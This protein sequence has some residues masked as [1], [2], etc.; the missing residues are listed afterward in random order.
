VVEIERNTDLAVVD[1]V[2]RALKI[3]SSVATCFAIIPE[4]TAA[5]GLSSGLCVL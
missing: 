2:T 3:L 1:G 4:A 5:H